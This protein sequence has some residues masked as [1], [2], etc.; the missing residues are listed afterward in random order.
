[1]ATWPVVAGEERFLLADGPAK[2]S[3]NYKEDIY[4]L[5]TLFPADMLPLTMS[6]KAASHYSFYFFFGERVQYLR[7]PVTNPEMDYHA[8]VNRKTDHDEERQD[9][10]VTETQTWLLAMSILLSPTF[11]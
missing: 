4:S 10:I 8:G 5:I 9:R 11:W 6:K 7:L 3:L 1:M 2:S